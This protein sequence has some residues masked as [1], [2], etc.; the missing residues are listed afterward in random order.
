MSYKNG[1]VRHFPDL[2]CHLM[3]RRS[4]SQHLIGDTGQP[5]NKR[6]QRSPR[7]YECA[8]PFDHLLPIMQQNSNFSYAMSSSI[9][10]CSFNVDDGVSGIHFS[11][12]QK[13]I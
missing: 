13:P 1:I 8:I 10:S 6:R 2:L 12:V 9:S 7:I 11:K 4:F 3:K 5:G